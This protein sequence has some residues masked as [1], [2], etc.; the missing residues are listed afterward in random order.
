[1]NRQRVASAAVSA[2]LLIA[3]FAFGGITAKL[4]AV[5]FVLIAI[6]LIWFS[7]AVSEAERRQDLRYIR[8]ATFGLY[9]P[10]PD[11]WGLVGSSPGL[12]RG[13]GWMLLGAGWLVLIVS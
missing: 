5:L 11:N 8:F 1:M 2:A 4:L 10:N 3:A 13:F 6:P 12:L 7:T 9:R